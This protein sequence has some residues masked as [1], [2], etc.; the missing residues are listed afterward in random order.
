MT[1]PIY[2]DIDD[3]KERFSEAEIVQLTDRDRDGNVDDDV[4]NQALLDADAEIN[5]AVGVRYGLPLPSVPDLINRLACDIARYRLYDD[6]PTDEVRRRYEDAVAELDKI[7]KGTRDLQF[8][9]ATEESSSKFR[10]GQVKSCIDWKA[11]G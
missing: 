2:A 3:L 7:A 1:A 10:T 9:G 5:A 4:A 6:K 8:P 11:Y